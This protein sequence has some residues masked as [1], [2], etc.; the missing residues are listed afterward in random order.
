MTSVDVDELNDEQSAGLACVVCT[1]RYGATDQPVAVGYVGEDRHY[2]FAC[3]RPCARTL[4]QLV[5]DNRPK[6]ALTA[7]AVQWPA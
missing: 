4:D 2:V 3:P 7:Y 1:H 5:T 6:H